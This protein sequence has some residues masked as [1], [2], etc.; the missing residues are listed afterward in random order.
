M[1]YY[2]LREEGTPRLAVQTTDGLYDL[3]AAKPQ[4]RTLEDLFTAATIADS[5][6]DR[7]AERLLDGAAV[8]SPDVL[9]ADGDGDDGAV[10]APISSGEVW[11]AGVTYRISEEARKAESSMEDMYIDVYDSERPE[12]FFKATPSRTVGPDERVGIRA[13]SEWDVPEPELGVVLS[14]GE[15]VGY[16]IGNDMSSRSI[17][18]RNPLYLPQAKVYDRCC[19]IGPCVRSAD[20]VDDPHDLEMWMTI[21]RDGEVLYDDSTNTGKMVRSVEE[22]VDCYTSHNAV[23]EVSVLLTGTSLVPDDDFTL[24]EGDLIE[25]GVEDIGTLSNTVVEV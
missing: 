4:L 13:D 12:V 21:S 24:R 10:S 6:L 15:I 23:P 16:T 19:S 22:L 2:Q 9:D 11:A 25:I 20:S 14:D 7:V 3:T 1:R 8:L 5:S 17:E 18:G